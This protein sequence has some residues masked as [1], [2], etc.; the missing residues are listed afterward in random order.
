MERKKAFRVAV[1]ATAATGALIVGTAAMTQA[2]FLGFGGGETHVAKARLAAA[3]VHPVK[4]RV[5]TRDVYD[6]RVVDLPTASAAPSAPSTAAPAT[7]APVVTMPPTVVAPQPTVPSALPAARND[8]GS[9]DDEEVGPPATSAPTP[10]TA[11][12]APTQHVELPDDWSPGQ[13][14]P[15]MPPNCQEPHLEDNGVW[16]CGGGDD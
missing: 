12:A 7:Y 5:V 9:D 8:D 15:P 2:A 6:R 14:I 13:P 1:A 16:N 3:N 10:I 11:P 4:R